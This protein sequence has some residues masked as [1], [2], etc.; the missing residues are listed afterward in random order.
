MYSRCPSGK[1]LNRLL[2]HP[3]GEELMEIAET[4]KK[5]IKML[6]D[7]RKV[8]AFDHGVA[9]NFPNLPPSMLSRAKVYDKITECIEELEKELE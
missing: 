3:P 9:E 6:E 5:V 2:S 1:A 8:Y 7:Y 4:I